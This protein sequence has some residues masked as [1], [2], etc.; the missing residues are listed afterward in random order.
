[1]FTVLGVEIGIFK[2]KFE[3]VFHIVIR[4]LTSDRIRTVSG[5]AFS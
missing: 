2:H 3:L 4:D 1:M 5:K